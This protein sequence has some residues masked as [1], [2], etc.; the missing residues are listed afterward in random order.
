MKLREARQEFKKFK[1]DLE[2]RFTK[3]PDTTPKTRTASPLATRQSPVNAQG[4]TGMAPRSSQ[5][6]P[7][8][9]AAT[10]TQPQGGFEKRLN[11]AKIK[12]YQA[13]AQRSQVQFDT[14]KAKLDQLVALHGVEDLTLLDAEIQ[15]TYAEIGRLGKARRTPGTAPEQ[16]QELKNK[17]Q[18]LKSHV[19][20]LQDV[21]V[22]YEDH[23]FARSN[24]ENFQKKLQKLQG[25]NA[26][27]QAQMPPE[28]RSALHSFTAVDPH[29]PAPPPTQ[30]QKNP[31]IA[32]WQADAQR[33]ATHATP[34]SQLTARANEQI[35]TAESGLPGPE[36]AKQQLA[37]ARAVQAALNIQIEQFVATATQG[38]EG[39]TKSHEAQRI[40]NHYIGQSSTGAPQYTQAGVQL[41]RAVQQQQAWVNKQ[42][43]L[44]VER[45]AVDAA[46]Q[47]PGDAAAKQRA[48]DSMKANY[49][50]PYTNQGTSLLNDM[51]AHFAKQLVR[52]PAA[53]T[54]AKPQSTPIASPSQPT[55]QAASSSSSQASSD[56]QASSENTA[57]S[58]ASSK[59]RPGLAAFRRISAEI[60]EAAEAAASNGPGSSASNDSL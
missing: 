4:H 59:R 58:S 39:A 33:A 45:Y 12:R 17:Q 21:R 14:T 7:A 8:R 36:K 28:A 44:Q 27:P 50:N 9:A 23:L 41:Y 18:E 55:A 3:Q 6:L 56:S 16:V 22:A 53:P 19:A 34:S 57:T 13:S 49:T 40:R 29:A 38:L 26:A 15:E 35:K 46:I 48:Y 11:D 25:S 10:A 37:T 32:A 30:E 1:T 47:T 51:R 60:R 54:A 5:P 24:V 20:G 43:D 52:V 31:A 2:A 42:A